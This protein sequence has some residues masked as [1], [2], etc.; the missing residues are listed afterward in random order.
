MTLHQDTMIHQITEH[1]LGAPQ[2]EL[3]V[4]PVASNGVRMPFDRNADDHPIDTRLRD[5]LLACPSRDVEDVQA[6]APN[7]ECPDHD[8]GRGAAWTV[9]AKRIASSPKSVGD[10]GE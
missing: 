3:L 10:F 1:G 8:S 6:A 2:R 4:V 7:T 5:E 9:G